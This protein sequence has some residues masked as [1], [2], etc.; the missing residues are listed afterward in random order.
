MDETKRSLL[1]GYSH[2][3]YGLHQASWDDIQT[4]GRGYHSLS[5][6]VYIDLSQFGEIGIECVANT[7]FTNAQLKGQISQGIGWI[8]L[9]MPLL[10]FRNS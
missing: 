7:G 10:Q 2:L 6:Y 8:S 4:E 3:I 5:I 1:L 9:H